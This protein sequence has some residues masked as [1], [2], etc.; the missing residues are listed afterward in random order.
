MQQTKTKPKKKIPRNQNKTKQYQNQNKQLLNND[1]GFFYITLCCYP[2]EIVT[3]QSPMSI[4]SDALT[5]P[6]KGTN[7]LDVRHQSPFA[8]IRWCRCV[9]HDR[10]CWSQEII[11]KLL[12]FGQET[13][14]G[15]LPIQHSKGF[16]PVVDYQCHGYHFLCR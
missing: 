10:H 6:N 3:Y 4:M 13:Y 1:F 11:F 9:R 7:L 14:P 8:T 5:A 2:L 12:N 16:G 15:K